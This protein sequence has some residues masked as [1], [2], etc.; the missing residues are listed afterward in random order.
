[1]KNKTIILKEGQFKKLIENRMNE[2]SAV[3]IADVL[4]EIECT[5]ENIKS[6]V[7]KKLTSFGFEDV[8]IKFLGYSDDNDLTYIIHTEG[9]VFEF[10][11]KSEFEGE[12]PCLSIY[13]VVSYTKN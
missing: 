9:P 6:L 12:Q 4:S 7:V 8:I 11:A 13:D 1:M 2:I 10:K 3:E 5:G